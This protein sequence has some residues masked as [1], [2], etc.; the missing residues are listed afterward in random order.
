MMPLATFATIRHR[1]ATGTAPDRRLA[2]EPTVRSLERRGDRDASLIG[3]QE[4]FMST[5]REA[6][7]S[8][9]Q[10]TRR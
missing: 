5:T 1:V 8:P 10:S 4:A 3:S 9:T 7:L 2:A 6:S